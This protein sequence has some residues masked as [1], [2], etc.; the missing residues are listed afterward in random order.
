MKFAAPI[1]PQGQRDAKTEKNGDVSRKATKT[2]VATL[3]D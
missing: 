2:K 3:T 1:I